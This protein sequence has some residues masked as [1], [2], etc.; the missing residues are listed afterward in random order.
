MSQSE[1][2]Q[3]DRKW[4][5]VEQAN[6]AHEYHESTEDALELARA[7][8]KPSAMEMH[9]IGQELFATLGVAGVGILAAARFKN[10]K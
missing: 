8:H 9:A 7:M 3:I 6:V 10:R 2:E 1:V 4:E 5:L